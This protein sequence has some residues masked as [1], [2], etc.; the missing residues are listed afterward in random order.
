MQRVRRLISRVTT[1]E[2]VIAIAHANARPRD[3]EG[4][5]VRK[6]GGR[7]GRRVSCRLKCSIKMQ[8]AEWRPKWEIS[9]IVHGREEDRGSRTLRLPPIDSSSFATYAGMRE[10]FQNP[11]PRYINAIGQ[12]FFTT[13]PNWQGKAILRSRY[14]RISFARQDTTACV[15][16]YLH[17][18]ANYPRHI[19]YPLIKFHCLACLISVLLIFRCDTY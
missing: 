7:E 9:S 12:S 17:A 13:Q 19:V 10:I 14:A 18:F 4:E 6:R 8:I 15:R 2:K 16:E 1:A 3:S 5:G 11:F